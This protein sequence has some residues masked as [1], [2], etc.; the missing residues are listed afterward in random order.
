MKWLK[1][2]I[3]LDIAGVIRYNAVSCMHPIGAIERDYKK[4]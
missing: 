4:G 3:F 1:T 2:A